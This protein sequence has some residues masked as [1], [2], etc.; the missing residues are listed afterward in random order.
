MGDILEKFETLQKKLQRSDLFISDLL[1]VTGAAVKKLR[2]MRGGPFPGR[3]VEK[4]SC[5]TDSTCEDLTQR[6]SIHQFVWT[7][8][9]DARAIR[10]EVVQ[11][12]HEYLSERMHPEQED[13]IKDVKGLV[14]SRSGIIR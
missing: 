13:V 14:M 6:K 1:T 8:R 11:A 3:R 5:P 4:E 9:R 7:N 2:L 12:S 10:L